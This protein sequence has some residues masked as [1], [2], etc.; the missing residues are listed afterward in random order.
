MIKRI[1]KKTQKRDANSSVGLW[2]SPD[3][4]CLDG[5]TTLDRCPEVVAAVEKIAELI[6]SITIYL[7][8]NTEDGDIRIKNALSRKIDIE[9]EKHMTRTTWMHGI[10]RDMLLDGRGNAIVQPHTHQGYLEH[11]EPISASRVSFLPVGFRDYKVLIDGVPKKPDGLLHFVYN[12][13]PIYKWKGQGSVVVLRDLAKSLAQ[14]AATKNA[15]LESKWMP[16]L[17]VKVDAMTKEFAGVA[18]REKLIEDY[19]ASSGVGKPW[20]IPANQFD[21]QK[22]EPLT[23]N[24]LAITDTVQ[25]DKKTAA[26]IIGVPP[27]IVGVGEYNKDEYN[28][29]IQGKIM[30]LVK[31][32]TQE[33]TR[34][35]ITSEKWYFTGNVWSLMDYDLNTVSGVL[36]AGADRG[37]VCGN[38]W[39]RRMN[40]DPAKG[41]DEFKIL[42]NYVPY[43]M[44][45]KQKKLIQSGEE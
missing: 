42:E 40:L 24:D 6:A 39:R 41:L 32:I 9:P 19:V 13:S 15:F 17:V 37:Y 43:D 45:G 1:F 21:V 5:Y 12:P 25:I 14:A 22:I 26:A 7:M 33:M 8:A 11:L 27:F 31:I 20:I 28:A 18:G 34:K 30:A 44:S 2:L 4:I 10:V 36:L 3:P 29:F 38:E 35:L 23:L 16:I